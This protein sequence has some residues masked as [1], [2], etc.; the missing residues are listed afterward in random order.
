MW[1]A[2]VVGHPFD[3]EAAE[4]EFR[5]GDPKVA[6]RNGTYLLASERLQGQSATEAKEQAKELLEVINGA[7]AIH[8]SAE[9]LMLG[10]RFIAPDGQEHQVIE[11]DTARTR[12]I[13]RSGTVVIDGVPQSPPPPVGPQIVALSDRNDHVR[14]ALAVA[15]R[16]RDLDWYDL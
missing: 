8:A 15:G 1:R 10:S 4:D 2:E 12:S 6:S 7:L 3:L 9:P 13:A 5:S 11:V 16:E 14:A